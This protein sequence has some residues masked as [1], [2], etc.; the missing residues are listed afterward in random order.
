MVKCCKHEDEKACKNTW[1]IVQKLV[2]SSGN[3]VSQINLQVILGF[4]F[5]KPDRVYPSH[6]QNPSQILNAGF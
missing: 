4:V 2:E 1:L 5:L 6:W 3:N